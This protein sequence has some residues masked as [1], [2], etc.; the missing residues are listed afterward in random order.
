MAGQDFSVCHHRDKLGRKLPEQGLAGPVFEGL[1]LIDRQPEA[2]RLQLDGGR[3]ED[4]LAAHRFLGLSG[5][6]NT[7]QRVC[8]SS[9]S[10]RRD[11]TA[12]SGVP[13]KT[14]FIGAS[15]SFQK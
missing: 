11:A 15:A 12:N 8:P 6:V 5:W 4:L 14:I 1:R 7:P 13:I 9:T 10:R 2:L 3:R